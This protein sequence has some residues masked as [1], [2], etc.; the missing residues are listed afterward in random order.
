M[1][2]CVI[3]HFRRRQGHFFCGPCARSYDRANAKD[4]TI[5]ALIVWAARRTRRFERRNL[6]H[7]GQVKKLVELTGDPKA[8]RRYLEAVGAN[9]R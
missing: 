1:R 9:L 2:R 4:N 5:A 6:A 7:D 8:V 3:C